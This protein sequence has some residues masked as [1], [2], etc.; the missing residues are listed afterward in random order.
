VHVVYSPLAAQVGNNS[1][2]ATL[3]EAELHLVHSSL[4]LPSPF[5]PIFTS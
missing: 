3:V 4:V 2:N 5:F 1:R